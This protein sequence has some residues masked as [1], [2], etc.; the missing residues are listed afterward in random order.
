MGMNEWTHRRD[1]GDV[2]PVYQDGVV[3]AYDCEFGHRAPIDE[4]IHTPTFD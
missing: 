3:V 4:V 2:K 1:G